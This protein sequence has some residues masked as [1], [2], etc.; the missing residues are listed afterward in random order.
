[1]K[2]RTRGQYGKLWC[3]ANDHDALKDRQMRSRGA[4]KRGTVNPMGTAYFFGIHPTTGMDEFCTRSSS[5]R[6]MSETAILSGGPWD[7]VKYEL[8]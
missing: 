8:A 4:S 7:I 5:F 1:M 6:E 3:P 2:M